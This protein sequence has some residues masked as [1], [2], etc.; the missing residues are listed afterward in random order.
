FFFSSRR[1]HTRFS[2]DWSSDVCSSDLVLLDEGGRVSGLVDPSVLSQV[3]PHARPTTPLSAVASVL[4]A[5]S[6]VT[7]L[8]GADG[9]GAAARAARTSPVVVLADGPAGIVGVLTVDRLEEA[10]RHAPR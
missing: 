9:V 10:L 5:E 7:E 8:L 4:P 2:R 1:R 3:P 6:V